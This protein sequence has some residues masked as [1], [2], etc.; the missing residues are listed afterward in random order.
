MAA[1][2]GARLRL[3]LDLG[4]LLLG[5]LRGLR[6]PRGRRVARRAGLPRLPGALRV[7]RVLRRLPPPGGARQRDRHDR[8]PLRRAGRHRARRRLGVQRVRGLR[9]PVPVDEG[10]PR[11]PRGGGAVRARCCCART[12]P[13]STGKHFTL[14]RRALRAQARAGRA[15]DLDR[16]RRREAHAADRRR[17]ADG[18]NVPFIAPDEFARKREVL[19]E[20]CADAGRDISAIRCAVNVGLAFSEESLQA[21]VRPD[22]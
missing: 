1:H 8:P 22:R 15:A 2:R 17:W 10:A 7:A 14:D 6:V 19:A 9:H 13:T 4:P 12:S 18:W 21:P 16:W 3:D 20:H 11:H 5:R